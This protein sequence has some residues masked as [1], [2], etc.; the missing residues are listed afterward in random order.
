[1]EVTLEDLY[2]EKKV[3]KVQF[4]DKTHA[5][6]IYLNK[7]E[8]G[9]DKF[10]FISTPDCRICSWADNAWFRTPA[11]ANKRKYS[12]INKLKQ[13]IKLSAKSRGLI[14]KSFIIQDPKKI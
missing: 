3:I 12:S 10:S 2:Q 11:G 6:H 1:M 9:P 13:A 4:V 5:Y 14:V 7:P 8:L